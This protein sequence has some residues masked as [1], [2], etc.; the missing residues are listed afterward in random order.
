MIVV[1][2]VMTLAV[3]IAILVI[4]ARRYRSLD[5]PS[6]DEMSKG[7]RVRKRLALKSFDK[8]AG[9]GMESVIG[10]NPKAH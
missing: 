6:S 5:R 4:N 8:K 9:I 1:A 3:I 10:A 2:S 7:V